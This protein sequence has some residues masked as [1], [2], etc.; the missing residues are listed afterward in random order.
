MAYAVGIPLLA[1]LAMLQSAVLSHLT[2]LDGR[3][4]LVL[5]AVVSWALAGEANEAMALGLLGGWSLDLLS[6][7][8]FGA[9]AIV[10]ILIPYLVS[11]SEGRLW[12]ANLLLAPAVGLAASVLFHLWGIGLLAITGREVDLAYAA[13]RVL[14]PSM[15]LNAI[16]IVPIAQLAASLRRVV[17]PPEVSL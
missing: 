9:Q 5:L 4:D 8:P 12:G 11:F 15:I 16:V 2:L 13:G 3:P 10:L 14:L 7:S 1:L 6:S 17:H